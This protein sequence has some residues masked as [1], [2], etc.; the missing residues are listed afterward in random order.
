MNLQKALLPAALGLIVV[1]AVVGFWITEIFN[2]SWRTEGTV[3]S[4][5]AVSF[6]AA[7]NP[8]PSEAFWC[9]PEYQNRWVGCNLK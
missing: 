2:A 8:H 5:Y 9:A 7:K 3:F 4:K 6:P 1:A